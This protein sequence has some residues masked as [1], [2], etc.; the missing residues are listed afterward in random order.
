L[1]VAFAV[2][3]QVLVL[4]MALPLAAATPP[5]AVDLS[6]DKASGSLAVTITH[7][8]ENVN[9]HYIYKVDIVKDARPTTPRCTPASPTPISSPIGTM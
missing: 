9:T 1:T 3:L 4:D 7:D 8:S 5:S 6:F 2:L